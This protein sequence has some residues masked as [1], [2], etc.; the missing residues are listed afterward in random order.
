MR[1]TRIA[2]PPRLRFACFLV[3]A[4]HL[5]VMPAAADPVI[6]RPF[7]ADADCTAWLDSVGSVV[8]AGGDYNGDGF[9]DFAYG[10]PCTAIG[11]RARVGRMWIRSGKTGKVLRKAK[12]R[13]AEMYFGAALAF[14]G[15]LN[16]D[17]KDELAVGAPGFDVAGA[18]PGDPVLTNGGQVRIF[19]AKRRQPFRK[20]YGDEDKGELGASLAGIEDLDGDDVGEIL[21]GAPGERL[22][23]VDTTRTGAVHLLSGRKGGLLAR[24][25]GRKSAQRFGT[26][27]QAV[28]RYDTDKVGDI[29]V[30]SEKN[31]VG[32]VENA[33]GLEVRSGAD[34][35]SIL[36]EFGGGANDRLGA[37]SASAG[38]DGSFIVGLP[39]RK[40]G[41]GLRRAGTVMAWADDRTV[42][43][44]VP[45]TEPQNEAQF[46]TG[47]AVL[48]DIDGDGFDDFASSEPFVDLQSD[49]FDANL[50]ERVGRVAFL[51]GNGGF[52]LFSVQGV[53]ADTRLGRSLAGGL[54]FNNDGVPD[55][56]SGNPGDSPDG[57]R[58]AGSV[59]IYSGRDGSRLASYRGRRGL[60]TRIVAATAESTGA[61]VR[62]WRANGELAVLDVEVFAGV[63]IGPG[64][65]SVA[66]LDRTIKPALPGA[67]R[68]AVGTGP[69]ADRSDVAVVMAARKKKILNEFE[70]FP[71]ESVGSNVGAGDLDNNG[72]DDLVVAQSSSASG[73]VTVKVFEQSSTDPLLSSWIKQLEFDAFDVGDTLGDTFIDAD[74]ANVVIAGLR[75]EPGRE[76]VAA[77]VFGAPVVRIFDRFGSLLLEWPAYDLDGSVDGLSI[78]TGD[79]DG[80]GGDEII[81]APTRGEAIIRAFTNDGLP[82]SMPGSTEPVYFAAFPP[83]NT[84]GVR[85]TTA[86]VDLDNREEI[87]VV[88]RRAGNDEIRAFEADGSEVVGFTPIDT[89]AASSG[90]AISATD[91]FL[92]K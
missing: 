48:G 64:E 41:E 60:E 65:L 39:G 56:V 79:L 71:G 86:D 81:T 54:D 46:G 30:T 69:G 75:P 58:G 76:I 52:E 6:T 10:A 63:D 74:G 92:A 77:P 17:G 16:G 26:T 38:V 3:L 27:V 59:V 91:N 19:T 43:F 20:I 5:T 37:S 11:T 88:S 49:A 40:M 23:A 66:H 29:L 22:S 45:S 14:V 1:K 68:V 4:A 42:Q 8:T 18:D 53:A 83:Q 13:Q 9:E 70:A 12:G 85:L 82:F 36:L 47:V 33:G 87:L 25:V 31:P 67:A 51:S 84:S 24:M 78:A 72:H 34:P 21:V 55:L 80:D 57:R 44:S 73:R 62:A 35:E 2:A 15:D 90:L 50:E 61:R 32:G 7:D 28:G 89:F